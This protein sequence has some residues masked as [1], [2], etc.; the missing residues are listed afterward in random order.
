MSSGKCAAQAAHAEML[1]MHDYLKTPQDNDLGWVTEQDGLFGKWFEDGHYAKYVMRASDS[2]QMFT[3]KHYLE[4]REFKCYLVVDEGHT[5]ETYMVPTAMAVELIDK[6]NE[7]TA[8][9]FGEFRMYKDKRLPNMYKDKKFPNPEPKGFLQLIL[10][11][12]KPTLPL[13]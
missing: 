6:D 4:A 13:K 3:I 8:S 7:R 1:A 11:W 12:I 2:V 10:P 9:I 5:E